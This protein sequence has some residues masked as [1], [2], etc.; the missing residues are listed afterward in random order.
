MISYAGVPLVHGDEALAR[1]VEEGLRLSW[2]SSGAPWSRPRLPGADPALGAAGLW[3][4]DDCRL[5]VLH[6]PTGASRWAWGLFLADDEALAAARLA[7]S[8]QGHAPFVFSDGSSSV[9]VSLRML[10][11][12]P[13]E[14][15]ADGAAGLFV[16]P[17]V[18]DRWFWW[19]EQ[20]PVAVEGGSTTWAAL[21]AAI[22]TALGVSISAEAVSSEYLWPSPSL[23]QARG[24]LPPLLDLAAASCGQRIVR[25][26]DGTV[27]ALSAQAS[28]DL[29]RDN[30]AALELSPGR[31]IGHMLDLRE[32]PGKDD[33]RSLHV[34]ATFRMSFPRL[35]GGIPDPSDPYTSD[36]TLASLAIPEYGG[37]TGRAGRVHAEYSSVWAATALAGEITPFPPF[38]G[39]GET[40]ANKAEL[41]ALATRAA[42]GFYLWQLGRSFAEYAG[43]PSWTL[44][45][46]ADLVELRHGPE[47]VSTALFRGDWRPA[48]SS[49][50]LAQHSAAD[51][52]HSSSSST[53]NFFQTITAFGG[54]TEVQLASSSSLSLFTGASIHV[55]APSWDFHEDFSFSIAGGKTVTWT[56]GLKVVFASA[57][58]L[59]SWLYWCWDTCAIS[60]S[61]VDDMELPGYPT[62]EGEIAVRLT[63]SAPASITGIKPMAGGHAVA[64][65]NASSST[66]TLEHQDAGSQAANRFALPGNADLAIAPGGG[67]QLWYD[68]DTER[69]RAQAPFAGSSL[70]G[71]GTQ[72]YVPRWATS[73]TLDNSPM[74]A[75][76]TARLVELEGGL[77]AHDFVS[78]RHGSAV[79]GSGVASG[80]WH[81]HSSASNVLNVGTA[82][83]PHLTLDDTGGH[84]LPAATARYACRGLAGASLTEAGVTWT[85]G[86]RT[87]GALLVAA[88]HLDSN[89][90]T[91]TKIQDGAVILAKQSAALKAYSAARAYF[92]I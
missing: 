14:R 29:H 51:G 34:P 90:V 6:W 12:I 21:Y 75:G 45:A 50:A 24:P 92:G 7:E 26:F 81:M 72:Y 62:Q 39:D 17:L 3:P 59:C 79:S 80:G 67:V 23:G 36:V 35:A 43:A 47:K 89:A 1:R 86:I 4:P 5:G 66:I 69:W 49:A 52:S 2:P 48:P 16:L 71:S 91:T 30:L 32:V 87:G 42:R 8:Q 28:L 78:L 74:K 20:A 88:A 84:D 9:T 55:Y 41:D 85:G 83:I 58:E 61:A 22:G 68:G 40:P 54:S 44:D 53:S 64:L 25:R 19:L 11:A 46:H 31:L 13:A 63:A 18:D 37:K 10:P 82:G 33:D 60:S 57:V 27:H 70:S 65:F 15:V 73:S 38:M 56:G 76:P 77:D